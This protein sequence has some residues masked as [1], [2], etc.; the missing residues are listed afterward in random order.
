[1]SQE[2]VTQTS[3]YVTKHQLNLN[4]QPGLVIASNPSA[5]MAETAQ[6]ELWCLVEGDG[7]AFSVIV[8]TN[9]SVSQ[10][11]ELI[12]DKAKT[13]TLRDVDAKDLALWKVST[14]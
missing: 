8:P 2:H 13:G 12:R 14:L 5:V 10:L 1:M 9:T 6:Y 11:K 7:A 3:D 4:R